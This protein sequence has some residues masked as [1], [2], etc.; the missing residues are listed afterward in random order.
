MKRTRIS[1]GL[2]AAG[3]WMLSGC[4]ATPQS[5][6]EP[7]P[8]VPSTPVAQAK[9]TSAMQA[10]Y[11]A[12]LEDAFESYEA[13][14]AEASQITYRSDAELDAVRTS[15]GEAR[16]DY[17]LKTA[18]ASRELSVDGLAELALEEPS[19]FH[20][21]QRRHWGRLAEAQDRL[22]QLTVQP[23]QLAMAN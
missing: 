1:Q 4:S 8:S 10:T 11:S 2:F 13:E 20:S 17:H 14:V 18:L 16:F 15:L 3:L 9:D 19:F 12:A 23:V 7:S 21:E 5:S 22:A 6:N